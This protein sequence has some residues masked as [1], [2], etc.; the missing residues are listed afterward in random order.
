MQEQ[1][2][3]SLEHM[4]DSLDSLATSLTEK[5]SRQV[6]KRSQIEQRWLEDLR[7]FHGEYSPEELKG[8]EGSKI[9]TNLTRN[10]TNAAEARCQDMLFPTDDRNWGIKPTPVP[11][12]TGSAGSA[13]GD[14]RQA[15]AMADAMQTEIDDQLNESKYPLKS[16]DIIHDACQ[17][18]TG[19]L[20]GPVVVGRSKRHWRKAEN[21]FELDVKEDLAAA[22][23][24]VD[25]WNFFPDMS[26][27]TIEEAEFIFERH[28]WTKKQLRE[29]SKLPNTIT[30]NINEFAK[31][32]RDEASIAKNYIDDIR[33]ITGVDTIGESN[34][35]EVWEYHGPIKK[36]QLIDALSIA[37]ADEKTLDEVDN[38]DNELYGIVFFSSNKVLKV[39]LNSMDTE[40]FP[41][42]V[43]N[44]E[45]DESCIF[46][47]GV[48]YLMRNPQKIINASM[49]M[50]MDNGGQSVADQIVIN[51]SLVQPADG[52]WALTPKK[53]WLTREGKTVTDIRAAFQSFS[54]QSHQAELANIFSLGRQLADEETNLPLIAQ[55]EQ[56]GHITQTA[57]GMSMLMNS[58]NIV[59]RRAVKNWDD[60]IT[61]TLIGRF[62]DW[63]MQYGENDDIKG[64]Y[65]I[66][67]RGSGAL[68]VKEKQQENLMVYANIAAGNPEFSIRTDWKG[69]HE[70]IAKSLEIPIDKIALSEEEVTQRQEEARKAAENQPSD[71]SLQ[72]NQAKLQLEQMKLQADAEYKQASLQQEAQIKQMELEQK[73]EL[74]LAE[75]AARN[76]ITIA[77]LEAK[78]GIE[79][80]REQNKRDMAALKANQEQTKLHLQAENLSQGRDTF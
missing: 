49:R 20:K 5:A 44:W 50:M 78:V 52:K 36:Q 23:E 13:H 79:E 67:A 39:S 66:D 54:T 24:R 40:E 47:F 10:K 68:L 63:N 73:R 35:Y 11:V 2:P 22:V 59:L 58:A 45:K 55:G 64:D 33:E 76:E 65:T 57:Q 46:G 34:K 17:C 72:L 8:V 77:Q 51:Q 75:I 7:Q 6:S 41:Y 37:Q 43:F 3:R 69:L 30:S 38:L 1:Q 21:G 18:G 29:F 26:A 28:L 60:D 70:Q 19:V 4:K 9:F 80:K 32:D 27:R 12:I 56:A 31:G 53:V 25:Y 14:D 42:S 16:R 48:P 74:G 15:K 71:P 61:R 62:Y